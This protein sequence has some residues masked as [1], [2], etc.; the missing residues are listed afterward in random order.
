[1]GN[2]QGH[3]RHPVIN[4][5]LH[6]RACGYERNGNP[7]VGGAK[8]G[9]VVEGGG[10]RGV[11][12]GGALVAM[13]QMGLTKVFDAVYGESAGGINACYFLAGQAQFGS[14]IYLD[15]LTSLRFV[16]PLR[17]GSILDM[18]YAIDIVIKTVKRLDIQKVL[19]SRAALYIA[20]TNAV[21]GK[22]RL[23]D[24]KHDSVPLLTLLKA[25]GA[26]APLYN[27]PVL[28]DGVAYADGGITNPIPV[29]SAIDDGC[30]HILV[31][32]TRPPEYISPPY[33]AFQRFCLRPLFRSW[34][35]EFVNAFYECRYRG[36]NETR[37]IAFGNTVV[38]KGVSIAVIGPDAASPP[39][40]R[41]TISRR[42]LKA[43][44]ED[45]MCKTRECFHGSSP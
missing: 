34:S 16:N 11:Y 27:R 41:A 8:V 22:P 35:R 6:R 39:I 21:T 9:L 17:L 7:S 2:N 20:V 25:T 33:T 32:L 3:S 5:I 1:M 19:A 26:I 31:L 15:D 44:M 12:S 13:E 43:A 42:R 28:I 45:A 18:D 10:M 4:E 36:Y 23:V 40:S 38:R 37:S 29:K 24:V 30:T 14:S